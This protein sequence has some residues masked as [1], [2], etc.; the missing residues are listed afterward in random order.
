MAEYFPIAT[1]ETGVYKTA[2]PKVELDG[3]ALS[4]PATR[5]FDAAVTDGDLADA[6]TVFVYIRKTADTTVW[7]AWE[8]TFNNATPDTVDQVALISSA[9][10]FSNNDPVDIWCHADSLP[11]AKHSAARGFIEGYNLEWLANSG[12]AIRATDGRVTING[13][14]Y[15]DTANVTT[16]T[17]D[18]VTAGSFTGTAD[19]HYFVYLWDD[20]GT[21]KLEIDQGSV[22]AGAFTNEPTYDSALD[23]YKHPASGAAYRFIG[24]FH[25]DGSG[26]CEEFKSVIEGPRTRAIYSEEAQ[27]HWIVSGVA[28]T[29]TWTAF[30]MAPYIPSIAIDGLYTAAI[31]NSGG[32][33]AQLLITMHMHGSLATTVAGMYSAR[34]YMA[35]SGWLYFPPSW[36][37]IDGLTSWYWTNTSLSGLS[38]S[39][40]NYIGWKGSRFKI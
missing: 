35:A 14:H 21:R 34:G 4:T 30:N 27:S 31:Q 26:N 29:T 3:T 37:P 12:S 11:R 1:G 39:Y 20:S 6:G 22:T 38:S 19:T 36:I 10:T 23:Y 17:G 13:I 9:G 25:C 15:E 7:A 40:S 24:D 8:A 28:K 2:G 32:S 5:L 18:G 33:T 16:L